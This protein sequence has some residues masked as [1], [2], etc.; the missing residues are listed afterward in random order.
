MCQTSDWR[1]TPITAHK[2][3]CLSVIHLT[4][5]EI[6][7]HFELVIT[8]TYAQVDIALTQVFHFEIPRWLHQ[9]VLQT[10][11]LLLYQSYPLGTPARYPP[12]YYEKGEVLPTTRHEARSA[13]GIPVEGENFRTRPDWPWGPP[14]LLHNRY[15]VFPEGKVAGAWRWPPTPT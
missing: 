15:R 11:S 9:G 6:C 13:D 7:T 8:A 12:T 4:H 2:S 10:A 3:A 1:Q 5:P 14:S